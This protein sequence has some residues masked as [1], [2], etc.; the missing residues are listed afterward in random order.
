MGCCCEPEI[1]CKREI[2][3]YESNEEYG[4]RL[5]QPTPLVLCLYINDIDMRRE[6]EGPNL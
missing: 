3:F 5:P 6:G 4:G 1:G 2:N